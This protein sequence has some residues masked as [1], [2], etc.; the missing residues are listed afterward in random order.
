MCVCIC[1]RVHVRACRSEDNFGYFSL[2][3]VYLYFI[4]VFWD[5]LSVAQ[6]LPH[7]QGCLTSNLQSLPPWHRDYQVHASLAWHFYVGPGD[8]TKP[9]F[10]HRNNICNYRKHISQCGLNPVRDK[11]YLTHRRTWSSFYGS[12]SHIQS[13]SRPTSL[14][15]PDLF[16]T[17]CIIKWCSFQST[18]TAMLKN[19]LIS[20]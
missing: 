1:A 6:N 8:Q 9:P 19:I 16:I 15:W 4:F 14:W 18:G 10:Q 5:K 20:L 3:S 12:P 2:G 17:G 13:S 7:R 11:H